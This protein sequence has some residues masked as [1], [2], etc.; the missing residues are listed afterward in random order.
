MR[1]FRRLIRWVDVKDASVWIYPV[2]LARRPK[3]P[4][5]ILLY[6]KHI[7]RQ[8]IDRIPLAQRHGQLCCSHRHGPRSPKLR[9]RHHRYRGGL[10]HRRI[11]NLQAAHGQ[12]RPGR[13]RCLRSVGQALY[14]D[15]D[16]HIPRRRTKGRSGSFSRDLLLSGCARR[17]NL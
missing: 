14:I 15:G 5:I 6:T 11:G 8:K 7:W 9:R 10:L 1:F 2:R 3:R 13:G 16:A 12:I 17:M 4:S